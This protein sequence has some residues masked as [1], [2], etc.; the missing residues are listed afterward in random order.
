MIAAA[1]TSRM[2]Q[3]FGSASPQYQANTY[4]PQS[5]ANHLFGGDPQPNDTDI[6]IFFN[7]NIGVAGSMAEN[8]FYLGTDAQPAE[9]EF[10]FVSTA[11]HEIGH[12][13]G[14]DSSFRQDGS[15]GMYGD[16]TFTPGQEFSGSVTIYDRYI[17]VGTSTP[18]MSFNQSGRAA[19]V[20]GNNLFWSGANGATGN[21]D[22]PPRLNAPS[23][24][25]GPS[26]LDGVVHASELMNPSAAPGDA[27]HTPS[28]IELG[29][30]RD[31]G[32]AVSIAASDVTWTGAG[33]NNA[34]TTAANWS[35]ALP[36]PGD[37]LIFGA[38][39][40]TNVKFNLEVGSIGLL[41]F[42]DS[43]YVI[44]MPSWTVTTINGY[45][46]LNSSGNSQTVVLETYQD[47]N[48]V[49]ASVN[50]A[51]ALLRFTNNAT[52]GLVT[53]E[54][55][56]GVRTPVTTPGSPPFFEQHYG[57]NL[58]FRDEANAGTAQINVDSA[59]G[60]GAP[61]VYGRVDFRDDSS[62]LAASFLNRAGHV[63]VDLDG[64]SINGFGGQTNFHNN[65]TAF[66]AH[67][68]NEG[69]SEY[70]G[71][72]GGITNFYDTSMAASAEFDNRGAT[73]SSGQGGRTQLQD[74]SSAGSAA[75]TNRSS[76]W[77]NGRGVTSLSGHATAAHG[78]LQ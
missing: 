22:T 5:L 63:G 44:R 35:P 32:W 27:D 3:N 43:S 11:L 42:T 59:R 52:A 58:E 9:N 46:V 4:F 18:L 65:S 40:Q 70:F 74:S 72:T 31:M 26:H 30:L 57:A 53:Y 41:S 45:G 49:P 69:E 71:G 38:S 29:M 15:Y 62:A 39:P 36:L 64:S 68:I 47:D 54:V 2:L 61:S 12:G 78:F 56:G 33:P 21:A 50:A 25:V 13:L 6:N 14:Y 51:A 17:S 34:A 77:I 8:A 60:N 55:H 7:S 76:R 48:S 28:A 10:D 20:V 19:A 1:S 24:F 23:P 16:R 66:V 67:F 37:N 73:H 75:F